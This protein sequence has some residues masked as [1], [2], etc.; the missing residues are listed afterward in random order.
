MVE[1][2]FKDRIEE[3][4]EQLEEEVRKLT[5]ARQHG[6]DRI[7]DDNT[8]DLKVLNEN[9]EKLIA[10]VNSA[11]QS[12]ISDLEDEIGYLKELSLAQRLMLEDNLVYIKELEEKLNAA[13]LLY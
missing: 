2:S 11:Y 10:I 4:L 1:P 13:R 8:I 3:L 9:F 5:S 12:R 7:R 6:L